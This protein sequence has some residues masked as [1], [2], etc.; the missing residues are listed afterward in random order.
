MGV[1]LQSR[2]VSSQLEAALGRES[3]WAQ[4]AVIHDHYTRLGNFHPEIGQVTERLRHDDAEVVRESSDVGIELL[5]GLL[6]AAV[7][8]GA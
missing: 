1:P 4:L 6:A 3:L 8:Q 2:A 7:K 5:Y